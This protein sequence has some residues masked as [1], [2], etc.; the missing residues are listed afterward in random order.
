MVATVYC[1]LR[2][3]ATVN[4]VAATVMPTVGI[5]LFERDSFCIYSKRYRTLCKYDPSNYFS[6][7]THAMQPT[8]RV[9]IAD[10]YELIRSGFSGM[11]R[12][13]P[14]VQ[15]MSSAENG[16]ELLHQVK[17]HQPDIIITDISMPV[18]DGIAATL[19]VC[20][21]YPA[22]DII[23]LVECNEEYLLLEMMQAGV[24]GYLSK[25]TTRY[26]VVQA[27]RT[28]H[29]GGSYFCASVS[30]IVAEL[31][32]QKKEGNKKA[33]IPQFSSREIEIMQLICAELQNKEI[34]DKMNISVRT[35]EGYR[36]KLFEKT[37][38]KNIAGIALYAVKHG[39]YKL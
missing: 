33:H 5:R 24:R 35:V 4:K 17:L 6:N 1:N 38:A 29:N 27:I 23:A 7:S 3:P 9:V 28:V 34:A 26:E 20:Q 2:E 30:R 18:M 22:T 10:D 31:L 25:N 36:E 12:N 32:A 15:I 19:H 21:H 11:L 16:R 13:E 14:G 39:Y 8:I 37:A